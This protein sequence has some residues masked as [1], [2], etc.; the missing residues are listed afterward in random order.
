MV[1]A[2]N[3]PSAAACGTCPATESNRGQEHCDALPR[4]V[5][6]G[7]WHLG[8]SIEH[9]GIQLPSSTNMRQ[10]YIT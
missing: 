10:C 6:L 1:T 4:H 7:F 2:T 9:Q 8:G 5:T 3:Q